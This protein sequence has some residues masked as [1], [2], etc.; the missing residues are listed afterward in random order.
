MAFC[1]AAKRQ[2]FVE[3]Y[4]QNANLKNGSKPQIPL[5]C[6]MNPRITHLICKIRNFREWVGTGVIPAY[7]QT[8][9]GKPPF[10]RTTMLRDRY[11]RKH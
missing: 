3:F 5:D 2:F 4:W 6:T 9:T 1:L 10:V 7:R 11:S 8:K